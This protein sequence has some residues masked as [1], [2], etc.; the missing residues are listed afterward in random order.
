MTGGTGHVL[1]ECWLKLCGIFF[2]VFKLP[3]VQ[4]IT[5]NFLKKAVWTKQMYVRLSDEKF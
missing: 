4:L 3:Q 2:T 5:C 1:G